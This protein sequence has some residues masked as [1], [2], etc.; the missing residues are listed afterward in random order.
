M[1][2][3]NIVVVVLQ[4]EEFVGDRFFGN[5]FYVLTDQIRDFVCVLAGR[6][7]FHCARP[8][9]V[10]VSHSV[11][12]SLQFVSI[13]SDLIGDD[14]VVTGSDCSLSHMLRNQIKVLVIRPGDSPIQNCARFRIVESIL[15][16]QQELKTNSL[17]MLINGNG[18]GD[19]PGCRLASGRRCM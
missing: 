12:Q 13:Q 8:V 14:D 19:L 1:A 17:V 2:S 6:R 10:Q 11:R 7:N 3:S 9:V 4:K 5:G 16:P 15:C 18:N